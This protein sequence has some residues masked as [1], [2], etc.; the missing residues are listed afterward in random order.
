MPKNP[1]RKEPGPPD[2]FD[3]FT[4]RARQVLQ[5]AQVEAQRLGHAYIGTEHLLL[6]LLSVPDAIGDFVLYE[7]G[8]RLHV[9]RT[10][11][12]D[13]VG[14]GKHGPLGEVGLT[15]HAKSAIELAFDESRLL[16]HDYIGSEHLLLGLLRVEE[17]VAVRILSD[18]GL[19]AEKGR[20]RVLSV[21]QA[22]QGPGGPTHSREGYTFDKF[23]ERARTVL[24]LSQEEAQQL[25]H[26]YIGTEHILLGLVR[27]GDGVAARVLNNLGIELHKVRSAVE[28]IIGRGDRMVMGEIGLTPRAK[29]VIELAVDEARRLN[30][31]YIGTEHLLLGLVREGEGIAA[32][33]LESLGVSL[34]KVRA[35][36]IEVLKSSSGYSGFSG[37]T[38]RRAWQH[39]TPRQ[40]VEVALTQEAQIVLRLAQEEARRLNHASVGVEHVFLAMVGFAGGPT[41]GILNSLGF[42]VAKTREA[43][44]AI[45]GRGEQE[46]AGELEFTDV[47]KQAVQL[48]MKLSRRL[49]R[50]AVGSELVLLGVLRAGESAVTD[51]LSRSGVHPDTLRAEVLEALLAPGSAGRAAPDAE[52]STAE[53]HVHLGAPGDM[54]TI[55]VE[56]A[57]GSAGLDFSRF[58]TGAW[59]VLRLA[60]AEAQ[61]LQYPY[62]G[63]E[64]LL[65]GLLSEDEGVLPHVLREMDL[66]AGHVRAAVQAVA[67]RGEMQ[68]GDGIALTPSATR[69]LMLAIDEAARLQHRAAGP[70]HILLGLLR[71][72]DNKAA[73][74][75]Q[76]LGLTVEMVRSTVL[77]MLGRG[78]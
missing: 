48:A 14:L 78:E 33:V 32:G 21:L 8:I 61:R 19:S 67:G 29:R 6:G 56:Q 43:V 74:A 17:G 40:D 34:E 60:T 64:H 58:A 54:P 47:A 5:R 11:V 16:G 63:T 68:A 59:D 57:V 66:H 44:E 76:S 42:E 50:T 69:A 37:G 38:V 72:G 65:L 73:R 13:I 18:L 71:E 3:K 36:V 49:D 20:E 26:D 1:F 7:A 31:H 77:E 10:K 2:R 23:T 30:H 39:S 25:N 52:A 4:V 22:R 28:F 55:D 51:L 27:E 53:I 12:V 9:A 45:T 75:L 70:E 35:Q 62:I 15:Q 41:F 46:A 24:V